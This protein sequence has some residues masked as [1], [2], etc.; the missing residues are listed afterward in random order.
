MNKREII[1]MT[2]A[3]MRCPGGLLD[4]SADSQGADS[5]EYEKS[6]VMPTL[7]NRLPDEADI[8]TCTD[9]ASLGVTC[10]ETCHAQYPFA[11][12]YL[13]DIP[14]EGKAWIC[15]AIRSALRGDTA[16]DLARGLALEEA[17]GGGVPNRDASDADHE[18]D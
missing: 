1:E 18:D 15:C 5:E 3:A 14:A 11:E 17:L 8:K 12:M 2:L 9:F 4:S 10:C 7:L 16:D 13:E 6:V